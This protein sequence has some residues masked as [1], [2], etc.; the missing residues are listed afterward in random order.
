MKKY[1][2]S[3]LFFLSSIF[4]NK[5]ILRD[6]AS[7]T[8]DRIIK[9]DTIIEADGKKLPIHQVKSILFTEKGRSHA[10][11]KYPFDMNYFKLSDS[12]ASIY[13]D[14]QAVV[15][16][17]S[18]YWVLKNDGRRKYYQHTIESILKE[19][20]RD[21]AS[22]QLYIREEVENLKVILART[23]KRDGR[24]LYVDE[25]DFKEVK[26]SEGV[27]FFSKGKF[28]TFTLPRVEVGD[29]IE[30]IYE[31]E[32][33]N[34]W[35]K[36]VFEGRWSFQ[37]TD[38]VVNSILVV[39]VPPEETLK[40]K[41]TENVEF[42]H[43]K[44]S[45]H[46]R[47][48]WKGEFYAPLVREDYMPPISDFLEHVEFTNQMTWD[49]L[50][51]WYASFQKPRMKITKEIQD[52][53][54]KII[55]GAESEDEK[56]ARLYHWIQKNIRYISIKGAAASGVSGHSALETLE[57]GYGDCTDKAILFATMLRAAGITAYPVYVGTN[58]EV[59][60]LDPEIPSYYG[61]HAI[62][63]VD[64]SDTIIYLDATGSFSRYPYFWAADHG[65]YQVNALRR[66]V[67]LIPVPPP[68]AN[69]RDYTIDA[70]LS[71]GNRLHVHFTGRYTGEIEANLRAFWT[72]R[73]EMEKRISMEN[74]VKSE[75]PDAV[76]DSFRIVNL[77]DISK[78]FSLEIFYHIDNYAKKYGDI[79]IIDLPE[80]KDRYRFPELSA[81]E[82]E[83][84]INYSTSSLITHR[85]NL[86]ISDKFKVEFIPDSIDIGKDKFKYRAGYS[87]EKNR[88]IFNDR[89]ERR[90]RLILPEEY[91]DYRGMVNE[92]NSYIG[93]PV[94]L[95]EVR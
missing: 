56:I 50:F 90:G 26:P 94:L 83:F 77:E 52:L 67:S 42:F 13:Q 37:S 40:F 60:M 86:K 32:V 59:P 23:I 57:N 19:E 74:L 16:L 51:D 55:E 72:G 81:A 33:F 68:E 78:Q 41:K 6:G 1:V 18:G 12:I 70:Y 48:V 73:T 36:K 29:I 14:A 62:T 89:F 76:L 58:D 43:E 61:N 45:S 20:A 93:I 84:P 9:K 30:L 71:S 66:D 3:F 17:D 69:H 79:Y 2:I 54:D 31:Y 15:L 10:E 34:P 39:D 24:I 25:S 38:P 44:K 8:C 5:V 95:K 85:F 88:I 49:L 21:R 92:I 75:S 47:Y 46:N 7:I 82:R 91:K 64:K 4:A 35:N 65:V 27:V 11:K 22:I 87:T 53:V 63:E 28:I 80:I